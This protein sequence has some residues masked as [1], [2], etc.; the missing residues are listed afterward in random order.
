M[1][2]A[3]ISDWVWTC[4][5]FRRQI[6]NM[7]SLNKCKTLKKSSKSRSMKWKKRL[8]I[9]EMTT[10]FWNCKSPKR[11]SSSRISKIRPR[12]NSMSFVNFRI[13][14]RRFKSSLISQIMR[15][16]VWRHKSRKL[17]R[18]IMELHRPR[19]V[20]EELWVR[21]NIS[22]SLERRRISLSCFSSVN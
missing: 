2:S 22:N 19:V 5:K 11:I 10:K 13:R 21:S 3:L 12:N 7:S 6:I 18:K 1:C 15:N 20:M 9:W 8:I 14:H 16:L 17:K 4:S